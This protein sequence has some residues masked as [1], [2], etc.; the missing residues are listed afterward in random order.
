MRNLFVLLILFCSS[1]QIQDKDTQLLADY[2]KQTFN[3]ELIG[4]EHKYVLVSETACTGC[5]SFVED[6]CQN[7]PQPN[8]TY[9]MPRTLKDKLPHN[10]P[11]ILIDSTLRLNRL[12]FHQGNVCK[13]YMKNKVID[14]IDV[15]NATD[16]TR[17][18]K[19]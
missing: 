9:I 1:C 16:M 6:L 5:V 11:Q 4:G 13:I 7:K 2:L 17:L 19:N 10:N 14:H 18:L 12:K 15:Y 8:T 3:Q